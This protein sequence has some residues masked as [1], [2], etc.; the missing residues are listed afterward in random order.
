MRLATGGTVQAM[1][2]ALEHGWAINVGAGYHHAKAGNGNCALADIPLAVLQAFDAGI[3]RV[4]IVDLDAHRGNGHEA[5]LAKD[6]RVF[7]FDI[8][9]GWAYPGPASLSEKN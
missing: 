2:L 6:D 4:L 8:Y 5:I 9:N 7:I 3:E 1:H